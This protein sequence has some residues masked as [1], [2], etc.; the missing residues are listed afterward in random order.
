M[1]KD[2][3]NFDGDYTAEDILEFMLERAPC[4]DNRAKPEHDPD[5]DHAHDPVGDR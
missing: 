4:D 3:K 1:A 5:P 2:K